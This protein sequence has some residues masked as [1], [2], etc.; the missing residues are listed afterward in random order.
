MGQGGQAAERPVEANNPAPPAPNPQNNLPPQSNFHT[1]K[2]S[3]FANFGPIIF[4]VMDDDIG[5]N[6]QR[7][8]LD[9]FYISSRML[10][11]ISIV[12]FYSSL[13]RFLL[14][15]SLGMLLYL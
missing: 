7:D 5:G 9:Y 11:L 13:H 10:V 12:Y 3:F 6:R 15:T 8:W 14:V 4:L 2:V 1:I